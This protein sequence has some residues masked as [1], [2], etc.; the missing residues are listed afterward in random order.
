MVLEYTAD[1]IIGV[2]KRLS[3]NLAFPRSLEQMIRE[4]MRYAGKVRLQL[5]GNRY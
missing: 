4:Y 1:E 2:I 3:K 5:N